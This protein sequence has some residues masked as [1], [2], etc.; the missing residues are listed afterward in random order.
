M[1]C[2][3]LTKTVCRTGIRYRE[4]FQKNFS[5]FLS[6]LC[7]LVTGG[8]SCPLKGF[9]NLNRFCPFEHVEASKNNLGPSIELCSQG[10]R[11]GFK[12]AESKEKSMESGVKSNPTD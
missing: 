6:A 10:S 3:I 9:R 8:I 5:H 11:T 4:G 12:G 2:F 1:V 7:S